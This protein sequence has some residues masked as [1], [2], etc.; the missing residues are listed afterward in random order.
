[1]KQALQL[2][3]AIL[4]VVTSGLVTLLSSPSS[5]RSYGQVQQQPEAIQTL[6]PASNEAQTATAGI[7]ST[8]EAQIN[9]ALTATFMKTSGVHAVLSGHTNAV[10]GVAWSPDGKTLASASGDQT[11]RLW[12]AAS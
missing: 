8:T 11:V 10:L 6:D 12:D 9:Q 3:T 2:T 7:P 4:L 5:S 1:M